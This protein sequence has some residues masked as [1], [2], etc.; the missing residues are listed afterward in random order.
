MVFKS[1]SK[2][3]LSIALVVVFALMI[4]SGIGIGVFFFV[5]DKG[6]GGLTKNQIAFGTAISRF[7]NKPSFSSRNFAG[8]YD[9]SLSN[10]LDYSDEFLAYESD[11]DTFFVSFN[12]KQP[13][14][15]DFDF[16]ELVSIYGKV[17]RV[18]KNQVSYLIDLENKTNI[19]SFA[20]CSVSFSF[21][22]NCSNISFV[23]SISFFE[24]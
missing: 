3:K 10:V 6:D 16:D 13:F 9:G 21:N 2:K 17:A 1:S 8:V 18:K 14:V 5:K 4:L 12:Q 20:D 24:K 23:N 19:A 22:F 11:G 15:L 7:D